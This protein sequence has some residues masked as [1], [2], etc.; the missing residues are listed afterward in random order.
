M[1]VHC[2]AQLVQTADLIAE[3]PSRSWICYGKHNLRSKH[4]IRCM[5]TL[6]DYIVKLPVKEKKSQTV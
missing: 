4:C 6:H 3:N 1:V 5:K 2:L